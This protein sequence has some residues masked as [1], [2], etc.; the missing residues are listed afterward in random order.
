MHYNYLVGEYE[1]ARKREMIRYQEDLA[2][3]TA[4]T[5]SY[6]SSPSVFL[7]V[8]SKV[9][10]FVFNC[11]WIALVAWWSCAGDKP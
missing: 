4:M 8:I 9:G 2:E 6:V 1:R 7:A 3:R 10:G 5:N 11:V